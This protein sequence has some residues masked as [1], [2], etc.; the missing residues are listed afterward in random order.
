MIDYDLKLHLHLVQLQQTKSLKRKI[1]KD[2]LLTSLK[3]TSICLTCFPHFCFIF[4]F[5]IIIVKFHCLLKH[6]DT[7]YYFG[8][9]KLSDQI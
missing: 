7:F 3:E 5:C 6:I 2:L 8:S 4:M 1:N 9:S